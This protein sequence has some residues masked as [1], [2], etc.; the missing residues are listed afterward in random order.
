MKGDIKKQRSGLLSICLLAL[1]IFCASPGDTMAAGKLKLDTDSF[2]TGTVKEGITI[3][4]K[5][6]LENTGNHEVLIKNVS[7]SWACTTAALGKRRIHPG[8][9]TELSIK[10]ETYLFPG[11]FKKFINIDTDI[12][13]Q[14][15][16][17]VTLEGVVE[18]VPMA[19]ISIAPRKAKLGTIQLNAETM[20][21]LKVANT[22][23]A[24]LTITRIFS[25]RSNTLYYDAAEKGPIKIA[26]GKSRAV[27]IAIKPKKPGRLIEVIQL[28]CDARNAGTKGIYQIIATGSVEE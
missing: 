1:V 20:V 25:T 8:E 11:E 22:G 2:K 26:A 19:N 21:S 6:M 18:P 16:E 27:E 7:T 5:V 17:V 3:E 15:R 4:R 13:S 14:K 28:K 24:P 10:F 23:T 12:A 9:K